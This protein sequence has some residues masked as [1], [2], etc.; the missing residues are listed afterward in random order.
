MSGVV[1]QVFFFGIRR[2]AN[3]SVSLLVCGDMDAPLHDHVSVQSARFSENVSIV[4][5]A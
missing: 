4:S 1:K 3:E 2:V 5:P